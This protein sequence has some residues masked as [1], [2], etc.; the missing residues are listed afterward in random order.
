MIVIT[1][2]NSLL[3]SNLWLSFHCV[4]YYYVF[5]QNL[6]HLKQIIMNEMYT[7]AQKT[8]NMYENMK[9]KFTH[10]IW[11]E[12]VKMMKTF[13]SVLTF[14]LTFKVIYCVAWLKRVGAIQRNEWANKIKT[15]RFEWA[16]VIRYTRTHNT[17]MAHKRV[18]NHNTKIT[19]KTEKEI[20]RAFINYDFIQCH[21]QQP[22]SFYFP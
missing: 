16:R 17:G 9:R 1:V 2:S 20:L 21:Q 18:S 19:R 3:I 6:C 4:L 14:F 22:S 7:R 11:C 5:Q 8:H 10:W 15:V 13:F 12:D